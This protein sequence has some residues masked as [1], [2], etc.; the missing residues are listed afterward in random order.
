[1]RTGFSPQPF[2]RDGRQRLPRADPRP[3]GAPNVLLMLF[4][5]VG[6]GASNA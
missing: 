1:M 5:D 6:F 3:E 2:K 4:D